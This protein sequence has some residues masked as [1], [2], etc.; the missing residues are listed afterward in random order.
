MLYPKPNTKRYTMEDR[1]IY[2]EN[3]DRAF[4]PFFDAQPEDEKEQY[5]YRD[6][7]DEFSFQQLRTVPPYLVADYARYA[8]LQ[9]AHADKMYEKICPCCE[10]TIKLVNIRKRAYD[11]I[12]AALLRLIH[13]P[14]EEVDVGIQATGKINM[15]MSAI[16]VFEEN[17]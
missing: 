9:E 8:V 17:R 15:G 16:D 3:F 10:M 6:I 5:I 7:V 11:D 13:Y 1:P 12:T 2:D 4:Q 14:A